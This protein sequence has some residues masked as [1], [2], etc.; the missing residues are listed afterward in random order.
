MS[1][2]YYFHHNKWRTSFSR[3]QWPVF[4]LLGIYARYA[5]TPCTSTHSLRCAA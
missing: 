1:I 3:G 2:K 4:A 5:T